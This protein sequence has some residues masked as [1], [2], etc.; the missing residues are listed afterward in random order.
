MESE[1]YQINILKVLLKWKLH[2]GLIV[3][4]AVILAAI[5]SGSAFITPKFKSFAVVYPSNIASYSDESETEQMLQIMQSHD[6]S[7]RIIEMY[8]LSEHYEIDT[9]YKYYHT[10]MMY[11]YSQNVRISKTPY[12]SVNIEV[13]DKDPIMARDI[14]NSMID[15]YNSKV[16]SLQEEKFIEVVAMYERALSVRRSSLDSL[17]ARLYELSTKYGLL[18]Y[19]AQSREVSRGYLRTID[20]TGGSNVNTKEILKLKE[21]IEKKGGELIVILSQIE[22]EAKEF[23][24]FKTHYNNALM[25]L[26]RR[27]S[28]TNVITSPVVSDKKDYPVR[29][30]IVAISAL[31]AF[32]LSFIV[33]LIVENRKVILGN[34]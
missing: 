16:K 24:I 26:D 5:F 19:E 27:F 25:D 15:L 22:S 11:E 21:N 13:M 28:Y 29:W 17:E 1:F 31:S 18:D 14:V 30:L 32:F 2:L 23:A 33:V 34:S 3:F 6:I 8:K 12:E 9:A 20:G 10:T 4:A 7:D